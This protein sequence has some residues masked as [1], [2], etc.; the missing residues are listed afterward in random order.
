MVPGGTIA[1][2]SSMMATTDPGVALT[3]E[4]GLIGISL[5][6]LPRMRL[7][8]VGLS[9]ALVD[10]QAEFAFGPLEEFLA[11]RFAARQHGAQLQAEALAGV[12]SASGMASG[13]VMP[14]TL[15]GVRP[16]CPVCKR[17]RCGD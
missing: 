7:H 4:P 13:S 2:W 8:S 1:P 9:E 16:S 14:I 15:P 12:S 3:S 11:D 6:L 5:P 17:M 10:A